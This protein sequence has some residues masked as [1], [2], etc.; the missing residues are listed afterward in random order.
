MSSSVTTSTPGKLMLMG[1]HAVVYDRGCLVTAVDQRLRVTVTKSNNPQQLTVNAPDVQVSGYQHDLSHDKD[2]TD[3]PKAVRFVVKSVQN[4]YQQNQLQT[5]LQIETTS[6]FASTFGFGSSSAVTVG[7]IAALAN[8]FAVELSKKE[9]FDLAYKTVLDVQGVG[10]GFD[11]AAAIWGGLLYFET[12]GKVIEPLEVGQL[13]L[14]IG[15]TGVKADTVTLV[16]QVA[17]RKERYSEL[18]DTIFDLSWEAVKQGKTALLNH[19][20]QELGELMSI[21]QGLSYALGVSSIQ[22]EKQIMAALD[23]GALG[24]KL[25]GAGGGDCMLALVTS[26]ADSVK[27]AISNVGGQ[28]LDVPLLAQGVRVES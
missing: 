18:M 27:E 26:N 23:A 7:T 20:W 22:L 9:L 25:S 1:E 8:L 15:Y 5:G 24:A 21:H 14:L 6:E 12:G 4:F 28:V 11:L 3:L 16:K 13:P 17:T 10:S 2:S 19:D